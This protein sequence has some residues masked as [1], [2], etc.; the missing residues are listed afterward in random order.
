MLRHTCLCQILELLPWL[1]FLG[2]KAWTDL[3]KD[4]EVLKTLV[5]QLVNKSQVCGVV[6]TGGGDI[7]CIQRCGAVCTQK[8]VVLC[9]VKGV[10]LRALKKVWCCVHSK[11]CGVV[12]TQKGVVLCAL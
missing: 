10:M 2:V 4:R 9:A 5:D 1:R 7:L 6:C 8:G 12:C 3:Q 11:R